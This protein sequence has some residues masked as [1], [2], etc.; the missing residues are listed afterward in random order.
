MPILTHSG[1]SSDFVKSARSTGFALQRA[2]REPGRTAG[3]EEFFRIAR[4]APSAGAAFVS[5]RCGSASARTEVPRPAQPPLPDSRAWTGD[6]GSAEPEPGPGQ[7]PEP[8]RAPRSEQG[9]AP[10]A[11]GPGAKPTTRSTPGPGLRSGLEV[12]TRP[13]PRGPRRQQ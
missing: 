2:H 10:P 8:A 13:V 5:A 4:P 3:V 9:S 1:L 6:S 12:E 11:T 7:R